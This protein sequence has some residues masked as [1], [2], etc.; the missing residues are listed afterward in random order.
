MYDKYNATP[1]A[2]RRQAADVSMHLERDSMGIPG[3]WQLH[4]IGQRDP[5]LSAIFRVSLRDYEEVRVLFRIYRE[6]EL[7]PLTRAEWRA[8]VREMRRRLASSERWAA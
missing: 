7:A 2:G 4:M 6:R 3:V 8:M 5:T 1:A